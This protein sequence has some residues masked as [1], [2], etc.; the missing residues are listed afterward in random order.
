MTRVWEV[1]RE[2]KA[3]RI[4]YRTPTRTPP[5]A[6]TKK[7]MTPRKPFKSVTEPMPENSSNRWYNTY[8]RES[9]RGKKN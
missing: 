5:R 3:A 8:K 6:T 7:E 1:K 2:V 4:P 9:E